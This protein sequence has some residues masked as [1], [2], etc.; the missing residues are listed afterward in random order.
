MRDPRRAA[1][2]LAPCNRPKG[3]RPG[4]A[5]LPSPEA[6]RHATGPRQSFLAP[7][8]ALHFTAHLFAHSDGWGTCVLS[9]LAMF[10]DTGGVVYAAVDL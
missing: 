10:W 1:A 9:R 4:A 6:G 2:V 3:P 5:G 8:R 7:E